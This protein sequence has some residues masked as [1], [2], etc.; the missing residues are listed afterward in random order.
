M[1]QIVMACIVAPPIGNFEGLQNARRC[2]RGKPRRTQSVWLLEFSF[3][4]CVVFVVAAALL[5]AQDLFYY[6]SICS[7]GRFPTCACGSR[8]VPARLAPPSPGVSGFAPLSG[9]LGLIF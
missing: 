2:R 4:R 8:H 9:S 5:S 7:F 3:F 6:I 1:N